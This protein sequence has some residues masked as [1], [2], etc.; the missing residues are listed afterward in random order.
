MTGDEADP[1]LLLHGWPQT[2]A[3]WKP[4]L[5][6]LAERYVVYAC[7]LPGVSGSTNSDDD[8]SKKGM[9]EDIR[10][11][12]PAAGIG[13]LHPVGHDID[14]KT[15]YAYARAFAD[16][17][18]TVS[19]IE[20]PLPGTDMFDQTMGSDMAWHIAFNAVPEVAERIVG[21]DVEYVVTHFIGSFCSVEGGPDADHADAC[22]VAYSD[23]DT[24][25]VGFE[26]YGAPAW[27]AADDAAAFATPLAM[28]VRAPSAGGVAPGTYIARMVKPLVRN[29][30]GGAGR[31]GGH[32][33][34][35]EE[36]EETA[37]RLLGVL[38]ARPVTGTR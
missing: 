1:V 14:G 12:C 34:S 17:V 16:D 30:S 23:P 25:A 2:A 15:A 5:R 7:D 37:T 32:W 33:V 4:V 24:L 28:P 11:A 19:I 35:K 8:L 38:A 36:P 20:V 31:G 18:A 9:A 3:G 26:F 6:A 10:A 21:H 22:M 29:G 13:Q 27:D